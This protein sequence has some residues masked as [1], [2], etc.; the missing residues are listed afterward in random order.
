MTICCNHNCNQRRTCPIDA[1]HR[2]ATMA[3]VT[4]KAYDTETNGGGEPIYP[5][6]TN[7]VAIVV[8]SLHDA[9]LATLPAAEPVRSYPL[10]DAI[11]NLSIGFVVGALVVVAMV[12]A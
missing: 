7:D 4:R 8:S 5:E 10:T 1:A 9:H 11:G 3:Q 12:S 2:L 6:W